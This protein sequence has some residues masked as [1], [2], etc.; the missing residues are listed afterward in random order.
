MKEKIEMFNKQAQELNQ[1]VKEVN[2]QVEKLRPKRDSYQQK[3]Q[4]IEMV[5]RKIQMRE[6]RLKKLMN[7]RT[8]VE[9]INAESNKKIQVSIKMMCPLT[10]YH[11]VFL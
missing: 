9:N 5:K 4:T 10:Q 6:E 11:Q 2:D 7:E 3:L 8:T 1:A